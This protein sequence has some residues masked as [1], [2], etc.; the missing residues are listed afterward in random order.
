MLIFA[1]VQHAIPGL[2]RTCDG[3]FAGVGRVISLVRQ[4]R[5]LLPLFV[6]VSFIGLLPPIRY[7][8]WRMCIA[9]TRDRSVRD[10][11]D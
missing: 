10:L 9:R 1:L 7:C 5:R 3:C 11:A 6:I 2:G 8:C 4:L